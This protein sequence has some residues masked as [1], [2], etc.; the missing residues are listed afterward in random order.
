MNNFTKAGWFFANAHA[1]TAHYF[2]RGQ[3][4]SV[5]GLAYRNG[6]YPASQPTQPC[7]H[8]TK[9]LE[10]IAKVDT[11]ATTEQ[12]IEQGR[13]RATVTVAS[14]ER[15]AIVANRERAHQIADNLL[16]GHVAL[17]GP[18]PIETVVCLAQAVADYRAEFGPQTENKKE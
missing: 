9:A 18:V 7:R 3:P 16:G 13:V 11:G 8:C 14:R 1:S 10:R 4:Q 5:C 15:F 2:K 17:H 6:S 12:D